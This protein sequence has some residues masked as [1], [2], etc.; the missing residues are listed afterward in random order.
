L[1]L[2]ANSWNDVNTVTFLHGV[3]NDSGLASS[4]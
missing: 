3:D 2:C 4:R 1:L